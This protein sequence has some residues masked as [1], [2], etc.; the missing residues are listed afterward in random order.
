MSHDAPAFLPLTTTTVRFT[1]TD[2]SGD[3]GS[4][5]ASLT[6]EDTT[7][8]TITAPSDVSVEEVDPLGTPVDLGDPVVN[9]VGDESPSVS[10]DGPALFLLGST[11]ATWAVSRSLVGDTGLQP[12]TST[13]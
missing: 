11:T 9:D 1:A 4:A 8:P 13:M 12:V 5:T 7:A 6:V 10:R 2:A 3:T